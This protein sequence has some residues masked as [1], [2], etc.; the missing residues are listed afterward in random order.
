M[1]KNIYTHFPSLILKIA[2]IV[3]FVITAFETGIN[4]TQF[5]KIS[6]TLFECDHIVDKIDRQFLWGFPALAMI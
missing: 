6:Y 2:C 1:S 5:L 4:L 3:H